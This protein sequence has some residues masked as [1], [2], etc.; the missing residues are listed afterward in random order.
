MIDVAFVAVGVVVN[1][2]AREP[3][4]EE[5]VKDVMKVVDFEKLNVRFSTNAPSCTHRPGSA[6]TFA[7]ELEAGQRGVDA[8]SYGSHLEERDAQRLLVAHRDLRV[9]IALGRHAR[10]TVTARLVLN[11]RH[12]RREMLK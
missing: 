11:R 12:S 7:V 3:E 9:A 5:E 2:W 1:T 8:H 4:E 10:R 6:L